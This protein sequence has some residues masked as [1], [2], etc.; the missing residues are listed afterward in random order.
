MLLIDHPERFRSDVSVGIGIN[1]PGGVRVGGCNNLQR[2][3]QFE[4]GK[5]AGARKLMVRFAFDEGIPSLCAR[6]Y[7]LVVG[8]HDEAISRNVATR[9]V[10]TMRTTN[11]V[12]GI[13]PD[14][15][16]LAIH[17]HST[18]VSLHLAD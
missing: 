1:L 2:G 8:V 11:S 15:D 12:R 9:S 17:S 18:G 7:E 16:V 10:G 13:N 5:I 6:D 4:P 14:T 3:V